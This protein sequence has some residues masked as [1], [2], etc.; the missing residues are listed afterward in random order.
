LELQGSV[1][2]TKLSKATCPIQPELSSFGFGLFLRQEKGKV[3][4]FLLEFRR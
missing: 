2:V 4:D 3:P 1:F